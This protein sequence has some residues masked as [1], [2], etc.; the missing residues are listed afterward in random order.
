MYFS[1]F[2][3]AVFASFIP[4]TYIAFFLFFVFARFFMYWRWCFGRTWWPMLWKRRPTAA[5]P[6]IPCR[7]PSCDEG[8]SWRLP[9]G[10]GQADLER[11][12]G[13]ASWKQVCTLLVLCWPILSAIDVSY[14]AL[15]CMGSCSAASAQHW[16][17]IFRGL[18]TLNSIILGRAKTFGLDQYP[19]TF[20]TQI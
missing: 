4:F 13:I 3:R 16:I 8:A 19:C 11:S 10:W 2:L 12:S 6:G 18:F 5:S 14:P 9:K 15:C 1:S 17:V 7:P 20:E